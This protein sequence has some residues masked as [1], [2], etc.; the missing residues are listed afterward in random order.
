[1]F[2]LQKVRFVWMDAKGH[3][4]PRR[5]R[6]YFCNQTDVGLVD[7]TGDFALDVK[8]VIT[9]IDIELEFIGIR[10]HVQIKGISSLFKVYNH[11]GADNDLRWSVV[12]PE[13]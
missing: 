8:V 2:H 9:R 4:S 11:C 7:Q 10:W 12:R 5:F 13:K 3:S 1:M 6:L